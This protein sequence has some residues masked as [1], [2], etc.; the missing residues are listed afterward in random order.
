MITTIITMYMLFLF[1]RNKKNL[2]QTLSTSPGKKALL[3][4]LFLSLSLYIH[5]FKF[6]YPE[7]LR[8]AKGERK[9]T[10]ALQ[11][12]SLVALRG[13]CRV[14]YMSSGIFY[15][16]YCCYLDKNGND[17]RRCA[18]GKKIFIYAL[19]WLCCSSLQAWLS[20]LHYCRR[21]V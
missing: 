12:C 10:Y 21:R 1:L 13:I 14:W 20:V 6:I 7:P 2:C 8:R 9:K 18:S 15:C 17:D 16:Y 19:L 5:T 3:F 11:I 4:S